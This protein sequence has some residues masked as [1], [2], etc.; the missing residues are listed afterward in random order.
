MQTSRGIWVI[1]A[2]GALVA[3]P[4]QASVLCS[5]RKSG[6]VTLR[7]TACKAKETAVDPADIGL[8][9]PPGP[10][11]APGAPGANGA[12]GAGAIM[13]TGN[14]PGDPTSMS[15]SSTAQTVCSLA[16]NAAGPGTI[17]ATV[18]G[19]LEMQ[20]ANNN[21][22][23]VYLKLS[24]EPTPSAG[25]EDGAQELRMPPVQGSSGLVT[26]PWSV[27]RVFPVDGPGSIYVHARRVSGT[28]NGVVYVS[29]MH[30]MFVA[31]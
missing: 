3:L 19:F 20:V 24:T 28:N 15:L 13:I 30:V 21:D 31:N 10:T 16:F 12:A 26:I 4:V 29:S 17:V 25:F 5:N 7:P 2:L 23:F 9:G 11:G 14:A 27:S 22:S 8:M 18:G 6:Q 1:V